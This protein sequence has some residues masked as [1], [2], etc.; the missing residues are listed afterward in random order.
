MDSDGDG[1]GDNADIFPY[2]ANET[3]DS[4]GDGVGD[5]ADI[6]PNDANETMDSDGDGMGDN[7]DAFPDDGN[8]TLDSDGD[9]VGDNA[10][11]RRMMPMKRWMGMA[12][13]VTMPMPPQRPQRDV[14]FRRRWCG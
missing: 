1:M 4:D 9:G 10:D 14:G 13:V 6:F 5:N 11:A 7:A 12:T 2:D 3:M 8:E